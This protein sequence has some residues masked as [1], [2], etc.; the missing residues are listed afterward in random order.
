[1]NDILFFGAGYNGDKR[2]IEGVPNSVKHS[3]KPVTFT[4][5]PGEQTTISSHYTGFHDFQVLKHTYRDKTY[6]IAVFGDAPSS[7]TINYFIES[8]RVNPI[9]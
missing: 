2:D 1:M 4:I 9:D 7:D 8:A 5:Q 3:A 6:L